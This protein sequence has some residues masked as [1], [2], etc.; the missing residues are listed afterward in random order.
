M[1]W[2]EGTEPLRERRLGGRATLTMATSLALIRTLAGGLST[3]AASPSPSALPGGDPRSSG[4]GPGLVGDPLLAIGVVALIA[5]L[6]LAATLAY[7]RVTGGPR[8]T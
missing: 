5:V 1:P 7:V 4:Q 3:L 8:R 2:L 6:A